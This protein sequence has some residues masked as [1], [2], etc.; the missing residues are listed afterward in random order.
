MDT[1]GGPAGAAPATD[2]A[3]RPLGYRPGL[4][5]LRALALLAVL[6]FHHGYAGARGG[7]LG[8][9]SF[10]T[11]SGFLIATLAIA[12]WDRTGRLSWRHFWERR[13]RRL[14]PA[15]LV[16]L[17]GVLVLQAWV[18]IGSG[19]RFRVDVLAALGYGAN[20][21]QA[22]ADG[23]YADMFADPSPVVHFWS[24]AIEEQFYV[25]FPLVFAG[26]MALVG[27]A[28]RRG[29]AAGV[30]GAA[31]ALSFAAAWVSASRAGNDGVTYYG[32]HTR[33]GEIL[34]GVALAFAL[35]TP[36]G[37]RALRPGRGGGVAMAAAGVGAIIALGWLWTTVAIGHPRLFHGVTATNALLTA[38]VVTAVTRAGAFDRALG[39]A[40]LRA[41]GKVSYAAY[42]FHW[43]LFLVLA[44]P[45]IDVGGRTLFA[46]RLAATLAAAALSYVII[47]APFRFRLRVPRPRLA[48]VM[49]VGATAVVALAFVLPQHRSAFSDLAGAEAAVGLPT[50]EVRRT[51]AVLPPDGAPATDKVLLVGDSVAY[52]IRTGF[53]FWNLRSPERTFQVDTHI[54]F[55]C[56]VGGP[57]IVRTAREKHT[58]ADCNT[59]R[60]DLPAALAASSPDAVVVVIGLADL[61][62]REVGGAWRPVGD[63]VHDAWL[64]GQVD[65][66]ATLL[67][68]QG[69]PVLWLTFPHI[70]AKDSL[71]PTRPWQELDINEPQKVDEF[72]ALLADALADHPGVSLLA[73][74]QWLRTWPEESFSP[75]DRDGVHF[76]Y[77]G[78]DKVGAWLA[79]QVLAAVPPPPPPATPHPPT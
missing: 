18:E 54:A 27:R 41:V 75:E 79:P 42:L 13:A 60:P 51:G 22:S 1:A 74:D 30:F 76:S 68:A 4:D 33:A 66:V 35:A 16:A 72:N 36:R 12:E 57:G 65:E 46:I 5:G 37:R 6:A 32:T 40:P 77:A 21:R 53:H 9:S 58:F 52:S 14:L 17:A 62:G 15:A 19:P 31:A 71:D 78:S 25:L 47:E 39:V 34:V 59:W 28:G 55:G 3:G 20:W 26:V 67:E 43:P 63:P 10:F 45:R 56:P 11:L 73:F 69:V 2:P 29:P 38:V 8:V 64:R 7:Y 49:A 48:A 61:N 70:R 23:G 24:L 50:S 44:P